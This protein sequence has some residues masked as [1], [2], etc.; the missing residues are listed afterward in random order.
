[1]KKPLFILSVLLITS[2]TVFTTIGAQEKDDAVSRIL[3]QYDNRR[4]ILRL[5]PG[6]HIMRVGLT[7]KDGKTVSVNVDYNDK[8]EEGQWVEVK[9]SISD[10]EE[11]KD[12]TQKKKEEDRT[13]VVKDDFVI[14]SADEG[15]IVGRD[16]DVKPKNLS[17]LPFLS[18]Y[19]Y[20]EETDVSIH[21]YAAVQ[22]KSELLLTNLYIGDSLDQ[23]EKYLKASE[24][25]VYH[26]LKKHQKILEKREQKTKEENQKQEQE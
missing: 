15:I 22:R 14:R 17:P 2:L 18:R 21:S 26:D 19:R 4:F 20:D 7:R 16:I 5:E 11:E 8:I 1:M 12:R 9:M 3:G 10:P 24:P 13:K 6:T 25:K 23:I